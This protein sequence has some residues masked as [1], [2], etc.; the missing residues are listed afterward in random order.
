MFALAELALNRY[1]VDL[2]VMRKLLL[3]TPCDPSLGRP[4]GGP[5]STNSLP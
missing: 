2:I 4:S 1:P 5:T 3:S